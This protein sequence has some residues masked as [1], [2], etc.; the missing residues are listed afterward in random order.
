[1]AIKNAMERAEE[2]EV[3]VPYTP[4][5]HV[6]HGHRIKELVGVYPRRYEVFNPE[7]VRVTG[8]L[9]AIQ[10]VSHY[11][12][13]LQLIDRLLSEKKEGADAGT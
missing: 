8:A 4:I 7:G 2:L 3:E 13:A 11:G 12:A 9:G 5:D 10:G 6:V 1:M